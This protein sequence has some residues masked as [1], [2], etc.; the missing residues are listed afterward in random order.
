MV[1]RSS[2]PSARFCLAVMATRPDIDMV[3][4]AVASA[5]QIWDKPSNDR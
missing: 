4:C 2:R 5:L 1:S 3:E